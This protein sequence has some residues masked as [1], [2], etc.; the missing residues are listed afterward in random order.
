MHNKSWFGLKYNFFY[1]SWL[2]AFESCQRREE[3]L[4]LYTS[5]DVANSILSVL[6]PYVKQNYVHIAPISP[7]LIAVGRRVIHAQYI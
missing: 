6:E 2:G 3:M 1:F 5:A 7:C 4:P